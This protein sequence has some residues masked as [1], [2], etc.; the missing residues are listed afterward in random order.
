MNVPIVIYLIH[1][2]KTITNK[3]SL[4][5]HPHRFSAIFTAVNLFHFIHTD[6]R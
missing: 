3:N 2:I 1:I 6:D 4:K 5:V